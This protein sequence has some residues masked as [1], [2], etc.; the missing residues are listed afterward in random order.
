MTARTHL[1]VLAIIWAAVGILDFALAR[2]RLCQ[3]EL[4]FAGACYIASFFARTE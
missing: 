4:A 2:G 1:K 3:V